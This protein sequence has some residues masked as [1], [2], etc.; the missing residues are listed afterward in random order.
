ML[1]LHTSDWHFGRTLHRFDLLAA[2]AAFV[3]HLVEVVRAER[4]DLVVVSGDVHDRAIP[5]VAAMRLFD[6][7]LSR[8]R[9]AGAHVVVISGNHDA[10]ARLGDKAG[11]LD[12]RVRIR[13]DVSAIATPVTVE[14]AHGPIHVYALPYLEPAAV[15]DA[16]PA[17]PTPDPDDAAHPGDTATTT[18]SSREDTNSNK[19]TTISDTVNTNSNEKAPI[20]AGRA[21]SHAATLG[22]AMRAVHADRARRGGRSIVCAHAW[23]SGGQASESERDISVGGLAAVPAK[24]FDGVTYTALGH[25]HRPQALD[26]GLRYSGSPLPYSF[27]EA[28]DVKSSL[29]VEIDADGLCGLEEIPVPV[30]RGLARLRGRLAELMTAIDH[31]RHTADFVSVVLTDPVRPL[32]AMATLQRR[33]PFALTLSHEPAL[34]ATGDELTYGRRVHGRSDLAVAEA[35]VTH[36]RSEPSERERALLQ[37][38]LDDA[39]RAEDAA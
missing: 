25:L 16:L 5:P 36:V 9:D 19:S 37:A 1:V 4:V 31:E 22:R 32:D 14:D 20:G 26:E 12:P 33:F 34:D 13:T 35:F 11:L 2:Q 23:V 17:V 21:L 29:L 3:D 38:A 27:S 15:A 39:R 24:L 6:E 7:A 30:Y 10:G 8:V 18:D 28:G